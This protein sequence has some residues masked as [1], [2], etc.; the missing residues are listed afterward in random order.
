MTDHQTPCR[1]CGTPVVS[2]EPILDPVHDSCARVRR[3]TAIEIRD[4]I[5]FTAGP[6]TAAFILDPIFD[7]FKITFKEK[8]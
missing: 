8:K 5:L 4:M 2:P 1:L 7:R 3:A 6:V